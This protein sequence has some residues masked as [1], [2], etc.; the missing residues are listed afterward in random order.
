MSNRFQY[1]KVKEAWD[2]NRDIVKTTDEQYILL[3][4]MT[5]VKA[6]TCREI[7]N[8]QRAIRKILPKGKESHKQESEAKIDLGYNTQQVAKFEQETD[9][10]IR[11]IN[12]IAYKII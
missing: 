11:I 8:L 9:K 1:N 7:C 10:N 5:G 12:G 6:E 2:R 4:M 3:E